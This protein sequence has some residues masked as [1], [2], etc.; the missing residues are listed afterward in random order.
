MASLIG[1]SAQNSQRRQSVWHP[2][3]P[4]FDQVQAAHA[5]LRRALSNSELP[6]LN[7]GPGQSSLRDPGG[8]SGHHPSR[9]GS[10]HLS[11][12]G[13]A[14]SAGADHPDDADSDES[15]MLTLPTF[16]EL[17]DVPEVSGNRAAMAASRRTSKESGR[18][19]SSWVEGGQ[20][21][22]TRQGTRP[23]SGDATKD[24][25]PV[26]GQAKEKD[27]GAHRSLRDRIYY[28]LN[29][30]RSSKGAFVFEWIGNI[31]VFASVIA[32]CAETIESASHLPQQ[33]IIFFGFEIFFTS[34][35]TLELLARFAVDRRKL[36][37][38]LS[39][40]N[41]VDLIAVFPFYLE[42]ILDA[43]SEV[44]GT[45]LQLLQ[46]VRVVRLFRIA[47][48]LKL[49]RRNEAIDVIFKAL[50]RSRD[51]IVL[52]VLI[53]LIGLVTFSSILF[54][55]ETSTCELNSDNVWVYASY[56]PWP[57]VP[58]PFQN[59]FATMW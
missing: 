20:S 42:L 2:A 7:G 1:F 34:F 44:G 5:A 26:P 4:A 46:I 29:D 38:W 15:S 8:E 9:L 40:L 51:G 21:D 57:G 19:A 32:F 17:Q 14:R 52:L 47:R 53:L 48:L 13:N 43:S 10:R 16:Q 37:F 36:L 41:V 25:N 58:T 6:T 11:G 35:F 39:P 12:D 49:G 18:A 55:A 3:H 27:Y 24:R 45:N 31:I 28:F 50:K 23:K 33:E 22:P 56:T 54:V 59:V 30:S